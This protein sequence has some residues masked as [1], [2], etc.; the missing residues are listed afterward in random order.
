MLYSSRY[1]K[2]RFRNEIYDIW[3]EVWGLSLKFR[4]YLKIVWS[5]YMT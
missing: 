5:M 1:E 4:K 2:N 3:F